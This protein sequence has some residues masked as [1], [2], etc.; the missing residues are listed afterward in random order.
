MVSLL[1]TLCLVTALSVD[2]FV[3]CFAYGANRI[4]IPLR[5]ALVINLTCTALLTLGLGLSAVISPYIPP[6]VTQGICFTILLLLGMVKLCDSTVKTLIKRHNR[7]EK[8][9]RFSMF[10]LRFILSVYA[11]PQKADADSSQVLSPAEAFSL[12]FALSLDGLAVGFGA[13]MVAP[14]LLQII[15]CALLMDM[16]LIRLGCYLGN[17]L[18]DRFSFN[19]SWLG[20]ALLVLLA[21]LKWV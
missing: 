7:V 21:F 3:A 5:S 9:F 10:H 11:E 19:L 12:A 8:K 6:Q 18:A 17:K 13:G 1:E 20:G 2:A 16:V 14:H 15:L 4:H